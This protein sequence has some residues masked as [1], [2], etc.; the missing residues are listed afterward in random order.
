[1]RACHASQQLRRGPL[2]VR[3]NRVAHAREYIPAHATAVSTLAR[4]PVRH[5]LPAPGRRAVAPGLGCEHTQPRHLRR[6]RH[7]GAPR[8]RRGER[9]DRD[10]RPVRGSDHL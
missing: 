5:P 10:P 6:T 9:A 2:E 4:H 1:V 8:I 3:A 7:V